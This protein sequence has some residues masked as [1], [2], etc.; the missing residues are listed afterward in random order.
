MNQSALHVF[1]SSFS[2]AFHKPLRIFVWLPLLINIIL[3]ATAT[4]WLIDWISDF[5]PLASFAT[6]NWYGW[7]VKIAQTAIQILL[8]ILLIPMMYYSFTILA[9]ILL[10]PFNG[11]LAEKTAVHI[12][13]H[14]SESTFSP[15]DIAQITVQSFAREMQKIMYFLPRAIGILILG[16]IPI[17]GLAAPFLWIVF[18]IWMAA[19]QFLDYAADNENIQFNHMR[20]ILNE[21]RAKT[22]SFGLIIWVTMMIPILNFILIPVVVIAATRFW[23]MHFHPK[24]Q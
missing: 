9:A 18:A 14:Q 7:I 24:N 22:F 11:L 4:Y 20:I 19:L 5:N 13:E 6:D 3:L 1:L 23:F 2:L 17:I 10:S 16:F 15:S 8:Y 21:K 12:V